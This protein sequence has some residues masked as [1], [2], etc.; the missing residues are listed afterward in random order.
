MT[1]GN[2]DAKDRSNPPIDPTGQALFE[3]VM[4]KPLFD[5]RLPAPAATAAK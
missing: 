5:E 4:G 1:D 3:E 2:D